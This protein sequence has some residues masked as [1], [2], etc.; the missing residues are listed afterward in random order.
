MSL[1][2]RRAETRSLDWDSVWGDA[3]P[4]LGPRGVEAIGPVYAAVRTIADLFASA[5]LQVIQETGQGASDPIATPPIL[6]DPDPFLGPFDWRVAMTWSLKLRGNAYGLVQDDRYVRWLH[7]DWVLVDESR[8]LNPKYRVFGV[9]HQLAKNGGD[10]I[11]IR[12][13]IIP[14]SVKGLSP[15]ALFMNDFETYRNAR[16]FGRKWFQGGAVPPGIIS[17]KTPRTSGA[18]LKEARDD[19]ISA[20]S[21]GKPVALPG[22]WDYTKIT[23]SPEEAQFLATIKASATTIAVIFGIS[24]EDIG[25]DSG[26]SKTY[27]TLEQDGDK[28]NTRAISPLAQRTSEGLQPV[29]LPRQRVH[30]QLDALAQPGQLERARIDSEELK[31]GTLSLAE[32]RRRRGRPALSAQEIEDWQTWYS[33]MR[34]E[35]VSDSTSESTSITQEAP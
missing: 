35:S 24:P 28:L 4:P 9:E 20:A 3:V 14:G 30:F 27:K 11:H 34:S 23:I 12:D 7:P 15:I 10:L 19:F 5:P 13:S 26:S 32:A 21:E 17:A 31:N 33:T 16:E 6:A 25:G 1:F 8:I 18:A 29:L 2:T 22:E